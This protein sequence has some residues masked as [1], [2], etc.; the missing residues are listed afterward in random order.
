MHKIQEKI[1]QLYRAFAKIPRPR[2]IDGCPCCVDKKNVRA[3]LDKNLRA[4]TPQEL[5]SYA[6][7]AL[8]TVGEV[9]DYL[10][11]LPRILEITAIDSSW[12]PDPEVTG[13]AIRS[14]NPDSWTASQR[15]AL[16]QYLEA[17]I[18]SLIESED[19]CPLDGWICAIARMRFDVMPYLKQIEKSPA[20]VLAY[21]EDNAGSLPRNKLSNSFWELPCPAH[22]AIL[23]W[24]F[25][26][27]IAKIPYE[28]YGYL[29]TRTESLDP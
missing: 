13:R 29:I 14:T 18:G 3:L 20:A 1:E 4:I 19:Y 27:E 12:W 24:L 11:F 6:S 16:N 8:L 23:D 2:H 9:A 21:F 15:G 22:D 26:P 7:S 17:V 25:S 10:Y 5:T 28:A